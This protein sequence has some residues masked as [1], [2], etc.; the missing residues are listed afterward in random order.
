MVTR[1]SMSIERVLVGMG[2]EQDGLGDVPNLVDGEARLIGLD[3]RDVVV[4]GNVAMVGD[5]EI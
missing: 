4:A 3:Q 5:D 1:L 2:H